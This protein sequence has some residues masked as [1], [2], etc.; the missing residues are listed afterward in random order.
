MDN[1]EELTDRVDLWLV[2]EFA[3]QTVRSYWR[4]S[5]DESNANAQAHHATTTEDRAA[6]VA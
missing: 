3:F 1:H 4:M 2:R 5:S 6:S